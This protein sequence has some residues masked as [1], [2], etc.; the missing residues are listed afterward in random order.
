MAAVVAE[1]VLADRVALGHRQVESSFGSREL[2]Q[3]LRAEAVAEEEAEAVPAGA[4]AA[5]AV[6][7]SS[8]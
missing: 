5:P 7:L 6:R 2:E 3:A 4:P 8:S 1:V